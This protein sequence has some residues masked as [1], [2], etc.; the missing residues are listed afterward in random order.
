MAEEDDSSKT[1]EPTARKLQK[2]RQKGNVAQSQEVKQ[3][4]ILV[5][6]A[7]ALASLGPWMASRVKTVGS[8]FIFEPHAIPMDTGH[9]WFAFSDVTYAIF[10]T[11]APLFG[12]MFL[13]ALLSGLMQ[14]G[15]MWAPDKIKPELSKISIL[16]GAKKL[17]GLRQFV[18]FL[19]GMAKIIIVSAIAFGLTIP[20][21][22]D[23]LLVPGIEIQLTVKRLQEIAIW[24][25]V[26]TVLVITVI[27]VLDFIYQKYVFTKQMRMTKQEVKD[28]NKQTEGDPL[29]K[30]KIRSLRVQRARQR[31][32]AAVPEADVVVTNPT[33]YAVALRYKMEEMTAPK[34]IA[35][36]AD[37]VAKRI[38]EVAEENDVPIVENPPLARALFA[39]VEIDDEIPAEHYKAVAEVIGYVMRLRGELPNGD[40]AV[41]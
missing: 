6:A 4:V 28:E 33:H 11:L 9:I 22:E 24:L 5:G 34:L 15:L 14:V 8:K 16:K 40:A 13:L 19:K 20:L 39:A 38:R 12:V 25:I 3:W 2:A 36:G 26:G 29:I 21:I 18:E 41:N 35:K 30:A 7:I 1:E 37:N 23:I 27:A 17:V 32:M 10:L 31:M